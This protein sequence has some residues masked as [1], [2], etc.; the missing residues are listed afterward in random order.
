MAPKQPKITQVPATQ[1]SLDSWISVAAPRPL[2][3]TSGS[4]SSS[5]AG[6]A[7]PSLA[8]LDAELITYSEPVIEKDSIF[9]AVTFALHAPPSASKLQTLFN[10][11]LSPPR[12]A[13]LPAPFQ[14]EKGIN[15]SHRMY[16]WRALGLKAGRNGKA[17]PGDF[18]VKVSSARRQPRMHAGD[19]SFTSGSALTDLFRRLQE[20][21]DDDDERWGGDRI[22]KVLR[23]R[24]GI[25]VLVV[26]CRSVN[27]C[28]APSDKS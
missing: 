23:D 20:G 7:L 22:L 12:H 3:S 13:S 15:P 25:D 9:L 11:Y 6:L 28:N 18:E 26:C 8:E 5:S 24:G 4:A 27:V 10:K 2:A 14:R 1:P 17:G 21:S 19:V 16:A